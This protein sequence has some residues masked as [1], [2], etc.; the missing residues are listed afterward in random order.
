MYKSFI[1]VLAFIL[2]IFFFSSCSVLSDL[3]LT[4]SEEGISK[5]HEYLTERLGRDM[6]RDLVIASADEALKYGVDMSSFQS[7]GYYIRAEN[8]SVVILAKSDKGLDRAVRE[9]AKNGNPEH[10]FKTY[11]EGF[12]VK[13]LTIAGNDVSEY[14]IVRVTEDDLCV[15]TA[16]N[17][18][19]AYIEATCGAKL[20]VCT[21]AD[22]SSCGAAHKIA[23][24]SGDISLSDEGFRVLVSEDGTLAIE[25]G[26]W[27]GALFG[28]YGLLED[29]GWRFTGGA[30]IPKDKQEYLYEAE[31]V[32]LTSDINRAEV[33]S[34]AI[35]GGVCGLKQ[36][37][38]YS[39]QGN[40]ALGGFGF[41]IR[42]CHG[43]QNNHW[44][45][46]SGEY[47]G[48]YKGLYEEGR[49]P[50]FTNEDI[51]E[52]IDN[53]AVNYV[54]SRLKSGQ[55]IGR[56]LIAVDV[57][58]WDGM[59]YTFC[60][61]KNCLEVERVEGYHSGPY[62]RMANRVCELLDEKYPGMCASILAYCGTDKLPNVTRPAHNLYVAYCFYLSDAYESCQNHCISGADCGWTASISNVSN[63][64][65][66]ERFEEWA[67]VTDPSM[68]QI[69][70]YP[71]KYNNYCY[72]APFYLTLLDD[73]KYLAS[74]GVGHVYLCS[75]GGNGNVN[76]ELACYMCSRFAWDAS[77]TKEEGFAIMR[78]W[79]EIVYGDA[80]DLLYELAIL[81]EQAGDR[82]GC[83]SSFNGHTKD[84]VDY[85]F[86]ADHA[87]QIISTADKALALA[88]SADEYAVI[89]KYTLGFR[90]LVLLSL[91]DDMYVNGT[92]TERNEITDLYRT[93]W[94]GFR[95]YM[96][97]TYY[98]KYFYYA[99]EEFDPDVH[100]HEWV[101]NEIHKEED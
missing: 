59:Y 77:I 81:E 99:P 1:R 25:G 33:P 45:I 13:K 24:S 4:S 68:F 26:V 92:D 39:T 43:L 21:E 16:A 20:A 38:T 83:W 90:F 51:L 64:I 22:F 3:T 2:S 7:D 40:P 82:A 29:I 88:G 65:A 5:Y 78:E 70:Y 30:F 52:A 8:G 9:Y 42:S 47:E 62:L 35:R 85:D 89:D 73:M 55:Q 96:L 10:Y 54:E 57:A 23:I 60:S 18:L 84:H 15:S 58:Q 69:W 72:N 27:R 32:D 61:C 74:F 101:T 12:R 44:A 49:Q 56:E 100:P 95:G 31:H 14:A 97:A 11:N 17:E 71:L 37:N 79:F 87:G 41:A 80:G 75:G 67:A 46:F 50:C 48:L 36:R 66:A 94:E 98:G 93:V 34:I 19:A 91:Y 86:I 6:P 63:R 28:V 76:M 53:Y